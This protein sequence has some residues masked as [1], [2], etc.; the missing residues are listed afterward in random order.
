MSDHI[1]NKVSKSQH[2]IVEMKY[3]KINPHTQTEAYQNYYK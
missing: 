1:I 3:I 2:G